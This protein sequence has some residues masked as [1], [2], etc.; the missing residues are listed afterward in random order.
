MPYVGDT[1][2]P[3]VLCTPNTWCFNQETMCSFS[4]T[5]R[6]KEGERKQKRGR[7]GG[8]VIKH[9]PFPYC[10]TFNL[11]LHEKNVHSITVSSC[12]IWVKLS[13]FSTWKQ[14][15]NIHPP[16][17]TSQWCNK[18]L[19]EW[20]IHW[21]NV[22]MFNHSILLQKLVPLLALCCGERWNSP[23]NKYTQWWYQLLR[24]GHFSSP[25]CL[26]SGGAARFSEGGYS[27]WMPSKRKK[28]KTWHE[29]QLDVYLNSPS[30]LII[31][32]SRCWQE[33]GGWD[34]W[35][36]GSCLITSLQPGRRL[37]RLMAE[38]NCLRASLDNT[39]VLNWQ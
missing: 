34:G 14:F 1:A 11:V 17:Q 24:S 3:S 7:Q 25:D 8:G 20:K 31:Q 39:R 28:K 23:H 9:I 13:P 29:T 21:W 22:I 30:F 12:F 19:F 32:P 5:Q 10:Q 18:K 4:Q 6:E 37:H 26:C 36:I 33:G 2:P 16:V 27:V 15:L 38:S 35:M